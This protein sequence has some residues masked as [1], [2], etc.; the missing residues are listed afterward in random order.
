MAVLAIGGEIDGIA[1]AFERRCGAAARDWVRLRRSE[2]ACMTLRSSMFSR[3]AFWSLLCENPCAWRPGTASQSTAKVEI[4]AS[5]WA[6]K[7][8]RVMGIE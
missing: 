8:E 6:L 2:V 3:A 4:K 7:L 5:D 1:R